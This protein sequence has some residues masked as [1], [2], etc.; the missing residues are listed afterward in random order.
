MSRFPSCKGAGWQGQPGEGWSLL[1]LQGKAIHVLRIL[2]MSPGSPHV[3]KIVMTA[4]AKHL[5]PVTLELGG[6]N[7]CYVDDNCDPQTVANRLAWFRYF[8]TGQTCVAPDYVLCSP[9]TRER[10]VPALQNAI[11]RFYGDDPQNSPNLGRII[12]EKHFKRLKGLLSC[13]RVAIGGQSDENN[14]YIGEPLS[15]GSR[16]QMLQIAVVL[17]LWLP[18]SKLWY[19]QLWVC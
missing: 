9:E 15:P 4:A 16:A 8:N 17:S 18:N 5:T 14:L 7:P 11:T 10:L 1:G 2:S 13:G 6:K 12:S 3:G 19:P